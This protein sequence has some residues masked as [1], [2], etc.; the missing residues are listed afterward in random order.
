[1][2]GA[3]SAPPLLV[4]A[5]GTRHDLPG[6]SAREGL[7][8]DDPVVGVVE[9]VEGLGVAAGGEA[10]GGHVSEDHVE[11]VFVELDLELGEFAS[12]G[13]EDLGELG[14]VV[15]AEGALGDEH[16]VEEAIDAAAGAEVGAKVYSAQGLVGPDELDD[17]FVIEGGNLE[18]VGFDGESIFDLDG[19]VD[20]VSDAEDGLM[21]ELVEVDGLGVGVA[22]EVRSDEVF[23]GFVGHGL[24]H[25]WRL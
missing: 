19:V 8:E 4:R 23:P 16:G 3:S 18:G 24:A 20:E 10:G 6:V 25:R 1:M 14:E 17:L 11:A 21:K 5:A 9:L 2:R 15:G 12:D 13:A 7:D 22:L